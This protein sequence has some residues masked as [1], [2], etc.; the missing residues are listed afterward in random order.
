MAFLKNMKVL[1]G[2]DIGQA[3]ISLEQGYDLNETYCLECHTL[4]NTAFVSLP[5]ARLATP[6]APW[7]TEFHLDRVMYFIHL[8]FGLALVGLLPFSRMFHLIAIP[9]ASVKKRMTLKDLDV[10]MGFL[11]LA[12]LSACTQCGLCTKVCS[13]YPDY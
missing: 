12:G 4:P 8:G 5:I 11:D 10:C 13:V 2:Q 3:R 6:F 1:P 7:A 9:L